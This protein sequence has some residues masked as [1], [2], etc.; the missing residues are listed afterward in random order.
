MRQLKLL[1]ERGW[2]ID[3]YQGNDELIYVNASH[4]KWGNAEGSSDNIQEAIRFMFARVKKIEKAWRV[5][6]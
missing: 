1:L 2:A 5:Q 4:E 3:I 6:N